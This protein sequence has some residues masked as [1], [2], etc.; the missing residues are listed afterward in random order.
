MNML[1]DVKAI[2]LPG[3]RWCIIVVA[4][5]HQ[6][7]GFGWDHANALVNGRLRFPYREF[8]KAVVVAL[9]AVGLDWWK[10]RKRTKSK[11]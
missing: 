6:V 11:K 10:P 2:R 9:R 3:K 8:S 1:P 5:D 7:R 4:S